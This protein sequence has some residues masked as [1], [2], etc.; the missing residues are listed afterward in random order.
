MPDGIDIAFK[1]WWSSLPV[2]QNVNV[3][4]PYGRHG[5]SGHMSNNAKVDAK[6]A[7]LQFVDTNS[8]PNRRRLDSRNPTHY[9]LPR[10]KTISAPKKSAP[11]YD[12]K[13]KAS[14][15]CE[16]NRIRTEEGKDTISDFSATT[17]LKQERPKLAIYP[18]QADY[19]DFCAKVKK[20]DSGSSANNQPSEAEW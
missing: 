15:V 3:R 4:F 6:T 12:E 8:Q 18:H 17:W 19:C 14:L 16:F 10:F 20:R 9:L 11:N 7:F 1:K 5:L 13:V 2:D